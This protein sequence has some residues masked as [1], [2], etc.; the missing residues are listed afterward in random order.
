MVIYQVKL[1]VISVFIVTLSL[2]WSS[3]ESKDSVLNDL[4]MLKPRRYWREIGRILVIIIPTGIILIPNSPEI[5]RKMSAA[6]LLVGIVIMMIINHKDQHCLLV[7]E[8]AKTLS[9]SMSFLRAIENI[10][11]DGTT[12]ELL[13]QKYRHEGGE[14]LLDGADDIVNQRA[15]L[16]ELKLDDPLS[17]SRMVYRQSVVATAMMIAGVNRV[18][19]RDLDVSDLSFKKRATPLALKFKILIE[20][21]KKLN[22]EVSIIE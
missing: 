5:L 18:V 22:Y 2:L 9:H 12:R 6:V 21:A 17:I 11:R 20:L 1:V 4:L 3:V 19:V 14:E 13:I 10:E 8:E 15:Y 7:A 16:N